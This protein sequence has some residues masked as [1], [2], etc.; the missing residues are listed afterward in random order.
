MAWEDDVVELTVPFDQEQ[1][2]LYEANDSRSIYYAQRLPDSVRQGR[3]RHGLFAEIT[4][5]AAF[6][7]LGFTVLISE[8]RMPDEEGFIVAD[9]AGKRRDAD[10]AYTR[11]FKH[12]PQE[13]LEALQERADQAKIDATGGARGGDPPAP[14]GFLGHL[15][16]R[17]YSQEACRD[18]ETRSGVGG[19]GGSPEG[20]WRRRRARPWGTV[21]G[22]TQARDGA[23]SAARRGSRV[24][25]AGAGDHGGADRAVA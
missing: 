16:A 17:E 10:P 5:R 12:F 8:P 6:R 22:P 19:G 13:R 14:Q 20:D 18:G 11:M 1:R 2:D 7:A 24:R 3:Q 23:A 25:V 15:I 4:V 9:Y 21:V